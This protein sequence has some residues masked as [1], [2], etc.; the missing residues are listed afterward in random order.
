ML[1]SVARSGGTAG[2]PDPEAIELD[3]SLAELLG[4]NRY[5]WPFEGL[6]GSNGGALRL[7]F[8]IDATGCEWTTSFHEAFGS[9]K[10]H[11]T[12]SSRT[13]CIF[14]QRFKK[15]IN[16]RFRNSIIA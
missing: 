10:R 14:R 16:I 6:A 15:D 5:W 3:R 12:P 13:S 1:G 2:V 11:Q 7:F 8:G 4:T 9:K